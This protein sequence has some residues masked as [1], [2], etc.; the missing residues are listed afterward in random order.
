V[1]PNLI[2]P[3]DPALVAERICWYLDLS[4]SDKKNL[5]ER[6]RQVGSRYTEE[7]A[8]SRFVR[9]LRQMIRHF[10]LP[11]LSPEIIARHEEIRS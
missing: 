4:S 7:Q 2:V 5:S 11:D 1:D 9:V 8:V 3:L 10:D 6:G